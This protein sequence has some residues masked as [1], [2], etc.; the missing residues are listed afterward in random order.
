MSAGNTTSSAHFDTHDNLLLQID[1]EKEVL[2]W[3]PNESALLYSDHHD[4]WGLSPVNVD[5]VDLQVPRLA[6]EL[7]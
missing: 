1:G 6:A 2:L 3:H 4:K 7:A 5:R